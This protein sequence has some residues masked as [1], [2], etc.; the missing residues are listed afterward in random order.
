[1]RYGFDIDGVITI[2][3]EWHDYKKRTPNLPM[4]KTINKLY[5]KGHSISLF[6]SRYEADRTDTFVWLKKHG[7]KYHHLYLGK[8][9]FDIYIDDIAIKPDEFLIFNSKE[10]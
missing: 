10:E 5:D 1:M 2:E 9:K 7:V 6:S 3:T 4:I 8:P